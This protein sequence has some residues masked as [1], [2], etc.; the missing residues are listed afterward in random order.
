MEKNMLVI[1]MKTKDKEKD[2]LN[3]KMERNIEDSGKMVNNT[4]SGYIKMLREKKERV[5]GKKE[6][7]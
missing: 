7:E 6:K 2:F 4:E 5:N 3:G 1:F